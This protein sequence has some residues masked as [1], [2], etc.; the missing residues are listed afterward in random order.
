MER[1]GKTP[2]GG[3]TR[4]PREEGPA[5]DPHQRVGER[6]AGVLHAGGGAGVPAAPGLGLRLRRAQEP[7]AEERHGQRDGGQRRGHGG[8]PHGRRP[9]AAAAGRASASGESPATAAARRRAG[10]GAPPGRAR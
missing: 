3:R 8:D 9:A 2:R 6:G 5:E 10:G 1:R 7:P 4:A